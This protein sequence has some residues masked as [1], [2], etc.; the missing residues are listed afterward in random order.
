MACKHTNTR[1]VNDVRVCLDCG[2]TIT[3][4]GHIQFDRKIVNY[5]PKKR[6]KRGKK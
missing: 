3:N 1:K 5:K 2:M 4:D 6:K